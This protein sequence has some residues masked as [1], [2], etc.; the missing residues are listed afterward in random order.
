VEL[1]LER[2]GGEPLAP[3]AALDEIPYAPLADA[4]EGSR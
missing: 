3:D 1:G 2:R 4:D